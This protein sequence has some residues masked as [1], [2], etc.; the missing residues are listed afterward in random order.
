MQRGSRKKERKSSAELLL[1][2]AWPEF[3]DQN[4]CI[5]LSDQLVKSHAKLNDFDDETSYEAFVNH[6]HLNGTEFG[7][8]LTSIEI[9][10]MASIIAE[11]WKRKLSHDFSKD[12]FLI[13]LA[14]DEEE[15]EATLRFHKIRNAQMPWINLNEI[16]KYVE[17]IMF[18]KV[19]KDIE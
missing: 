10:R 4:G 5:L 7:E 11:I 16:E 8:E 6:V 17:P 14:F 2:L 18:I 9:I 3:V 13:I 15:S 12:E 19:G 1:T